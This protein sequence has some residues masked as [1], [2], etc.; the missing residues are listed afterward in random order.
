MTDRVTPL[1]PMDRSPGRPLDPAPELRH[2][3]PIAKVRLWDG[4]TPWLVTRYADQRAVLADSRVSADPRRDGFPHVSPASRARRRQV[5]TF[6]GMDDPD[7]ALQRRMV[8]STFAIKRVEALRPA[9]RRIVDDAIDAMLAGPRPADLVQAF[10]LPVPSMVICRLLGVPYADHELFQRLARTMLKRDAPV[11]EVIAAQEQLLAYLDGVVAGKLAAPAD[12]VLSKLA[13]EQVAT[14]AL[15]RRE[16]AMMSLLLLVAG[17]ET[18]ANMISLGTVAL[19]EHPDQLALLRDADDPAV[20]AAA[21]EELLRYLTIAHSG[22]RRVALEDIELDGHVIR[23]GDGIVLA[24]E[25]GNRDEESFPEPDR[26]DICRDARTHVAFGFGVHACLGQPLARVELQVVYGT[27]YRRIPTLRLA[28]PTE[29]IRF[30]HDSA[31]FGA[32]ELPVTW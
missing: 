25:A 14:G 29:E 1:Y 4:S 9:I 31:V 11:E 13:V 19:L 15:T 7:H 16:A 30:K 17:H 6:I 18:T 26:L 27:L 23:A 12:D 10:A 5:H 2:I 32:Y 24:S 20:V 8:T 22:R 21:V 28:V 3:G